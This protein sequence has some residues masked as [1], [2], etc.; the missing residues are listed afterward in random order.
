MRNIPSWMIMW[1]DAHGH[2]AAYQRRTCC[3]ERPGCG[4]NPKAEAS[5]SHDKDKYTNTKIR[6]LLRNTELCRQWMILLDEQVV[7]YPRYQL[8]TVV[9]LRKPGFVVTYQ[10]AGTTRRSSLK[11]ECKHDT[12]NAVNQENNTQENMCAASNACKSCPEREVNQETR[13][14]QA[15]HA[16]EINPVRHA[17]GHWMSF[18]VVSQMCHLLHPPRAS[19]SF[20]VL[21]G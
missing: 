13:E 21:T 8:V 12:H 4:R 3:E 18:F 20:E 10:V 1:T 16:D 15:C 14:D 5:V 17:H 2:H 7:L 19:N 6:N 9:C 11:Q